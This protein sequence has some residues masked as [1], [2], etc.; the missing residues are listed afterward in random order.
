MRQETEGGSY[1]FNW[2][3][4]AFM[5]LH[6]AFGGAG[7]LAEANLSGGTSW[8]T[9]V[10][11]DKQDAA[12]Y[13]LEVTAE[14]TAFLGIPDDAP[15]SEQPVPGKVDAYR[16]LSFYLAPNKKN[17]DVFFDEV[18]DPQWL[19]TSSD[20][21]AAALREAKAN[22]VGK[23]AWRVL[24]RVTYVS[25]VP[26]RFQVLPTD[27]VSIPLSEPSNLEQNQLI[28]ELVALRLSTGIPTSADI[29]E[30]IDAVLAK[31]LVP[32]LPWWA[33]FYA[34]AQV[35]NSPEWN[36]FTLIRSRAFAYINQFYKAKAALKA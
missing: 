13:R 6:V 29:G 14:P 32:M 22:S 20:T 16:F 24:H 33:T 12:G 1:T 30:A 9:T 35:T 21:R 7:F 23:A 8:T 19:K 3:L 11:K 26:P 4:G 31:D 36:T 17:C 5:E 18:I 28:L 10:Q 27:T 2:D 15:G 25:R 34:A